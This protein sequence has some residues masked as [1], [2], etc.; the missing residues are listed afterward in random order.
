MTDSD[1]KMKKEN[2]RFA[3]ILY[4][5]SA[6]FSRGGMPERKRRMVM[7]KTGLSTAVHWPPFKILVLMMKMPTQRVIS[8]K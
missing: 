2:R 6:F 3:Y 5:S 7:V 4:R 1:D 8:P